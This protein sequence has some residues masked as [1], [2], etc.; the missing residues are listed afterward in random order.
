MESSSRG[1]TVASDLLAFHITAY[2]SLRDMTEEKL[3][4]DLLGLLNVAATCDILKMMDPCIRLLDPTGS[5]TGLPE[6]FPYIHISIYHETGR[7][8]DTCLLKQPNHNHA[9]TVLYTIT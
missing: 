8:R 2:D 4:K 7:H 6:D 5:E 1:N 9:D 3:V